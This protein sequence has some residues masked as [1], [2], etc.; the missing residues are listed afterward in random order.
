MLTFL[1]RRDQ[2]R[3]LRPHNIRAKQ[4]KLADEIEQ[5]TLTLLPEPCVARCVQQ[6]KKRMMSW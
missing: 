3:F 2:Q 5:M 4:V 1:Q 6:V